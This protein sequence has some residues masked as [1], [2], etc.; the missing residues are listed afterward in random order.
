[1]ATIQ[2][3]WTLPGGPR[4][5]IAR[6]TF[7]SL[8]NEGFKIIDEHFDS[9]W[10]TDHLQYEA[11]PILEGWTTLTYFMGMYPHF[12]FGHTV[13]CQSFRNPALLAKMAATL[14]YVSRGR[15]ILGI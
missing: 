1:M 3:G 4:N 9:V 6:D 15:F 11:R 14:Q 5:N 10:L 7:L 13:L 12:N 2:F 8:L